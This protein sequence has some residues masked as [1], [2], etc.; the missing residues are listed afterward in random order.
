M[1]FRSRVCWRRTR[2]TRVV[3]VGCVGSLVAACGGG[4]DGHANGVTNPP[5]PVDTTP[6]PVT[7]KSNI[8]YGVHSDAS[9]YTD[10]TYRNEA[11]SA[12][13]SVHAQ[14]VRIELP[15][16]WVEYVQ[17]YRD[18]TIVDDIVN[19]LSADGI[20]PLFVVEGAPS[21]A[22]GVAETDSNFFRYVPT[23]SAGFHTF[24]SRFTAFVTAAAQRYNGK[25]KLWELGNEEN[26]SYYWRPAPSVGQYAAWYSALR[27]AI[28]GVDPTALVAAGGLDG[29]GYDLDP[30]GVRGTTF[31]ADLYAMHVYPD[32]V[33]IHPYSNLGQ[34]P[35]LHLAN[36]DNFD[37]IVTVRNLMV[38]NGQSTKPIWITEWGW[39][40]DQ[41]S[42]SVQAK[43][44][45]ESLARLDSAYSAYVTV[46]TYY[47]E[48]DPSPAYHY[49]LYTSNF[50]ARPAAT[51]F[52][53]FLSGR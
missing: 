23:D 53:N 6:T 52:R 51:T 11:I 25:V 29:L 38:A 16:E 45:G 21:W 8:L 1:A 12:A 34:S 13:K 36:A 24:V 30:P 46:A 27:T 40:V 47:S 42:D 9:W 19:K 17:G 10:T 39:S 3:V 15:W 2:W 41:V 37:D 49:G 31:L 26:D 33:A 20:Q 22:T 44:L 7:A 4:G 32:V 18:W 50:T 35:D 48:F 43:Y 28:R 5:V 14:V